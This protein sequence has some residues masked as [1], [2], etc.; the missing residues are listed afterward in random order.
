M[1]LISSYSGRGDG[2]TIF[3]K[4]GTSY[5]L[6]KIIYDLATI[7]FDNNINLSLLNLFS[8][9][10]LKY[11]LILLTISLIYFYIFFIFI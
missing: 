4:L 5:V 8:K 9:I 7:D 10:L 3:S 11:S 1:L 2:F 6:P